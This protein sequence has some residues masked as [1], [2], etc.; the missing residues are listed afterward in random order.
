LSIFILIYLQVLLEGGVY[1]EQKEGF[2]N[3]PTIGAPTLQTLRNTGRIA[4]LLVVNK[5]D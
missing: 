2:D 5:R 1:K 4:N 3:F